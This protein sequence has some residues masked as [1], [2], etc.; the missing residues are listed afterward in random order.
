MELDWPN[1]AAIIYTIAWSVS[2]Y[3]QVYDNHK[4]KKYLDNNKAFK[5]SL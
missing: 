3:G 5:D 1:I 2:F 4:L